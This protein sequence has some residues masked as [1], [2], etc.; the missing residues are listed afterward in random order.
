MHH[1]SFDREQFS[2]LEPYSA[3]HIL[4]GD[5]ILVDNFYEMFGWHGWW[6]IWEYFLFFLLVFQPSFYLENTYLV[7]GKKFEF[8]LDLVII[9]DLEDNELVVER[10]ANHKSQIYE[11]SHLV[12]ISPSTSLLI[13]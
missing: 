7:I 1:T 10:N 2:L 9:Q 6:I 3:P 5:D 4:I 8:S 12:P 11:S 13:I